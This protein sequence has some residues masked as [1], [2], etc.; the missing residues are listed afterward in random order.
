MAEC[1]DSKGPSISR[2]GALKGFGASLGLAAVGCASGEPR[3]TTILEKP[4]PA[5]PEP[6]PEPPMVEASAPT[7]R[8]T[9]PL[10][11]GPK[12]LLAGIDH[13]VVLMMENRSFD[14]YLGALKTDAGYANA[15][16]I[17]GLS[18]SE[19]NKAPD[20]TAVTVFKMDNFTPDD[21]PHT[22]ELSR[23]QWN[24]GKNDGFVKAHE[25]PS[26]HE[27]MGYHDRSQIPLY[28]W[29]ADNFSVCDNWFASVMGPTW[30]NRFYLHAATSKG[31]QS[32][33]PFLM[34]APDTVWD[35]LKEL[36]LTFKNYA[37][38]AATWYVA[39][40]VDK[41]SSLNPSATIED[42]FQDA[43]QGKLPAF[44]I[45]DPDFLA[46]DDHPDH[47]IM[48]G[49]A[50]VS[51]VYRALAASPAW[52]KTLLI[53]TYDEHGGFYDHVSPPKTVD[54]EPGFE[55]LGFR[56]PAFVIGAKVKK[57][58]VCKKQL[59]H[60]SV[61][62]TLK[63]RF[64]IGSLGRRMEAA[65]DVSDCIDPAKLFAPAPPPT[66]MPQVAMSLMRALENGVG[67]SSQPLLQEMIEAGTVPLVDDRSDRDRIKG[68]LDY[69]VD[70]G[71]I[72][73]VP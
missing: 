29:F 41:L 22:W 30:P 13:I 9:E 69:A 54:D 64:G 47:D 52:P 10:V 31:K 73:L 26:Q 5:T 67:P 4:L 71:A 28:Y 45:I 72:R 48:R 59:E 8:P 55:Q 61:A 60:V 62:A 38:G 51:S 1:D 32:N 33:S 56:V 44:S 3:P 49:Q 6:E 14:H 25:G 68:W 42:F 65:S 53:I 70:L 17:A 24:E 57:G 35:R 18:G 50:F 37:A 27:A 43:I 58:Y 7:P 12:E 39:G 23:V 66:G 21:L 63:T 2:R 36:G 34:N 16:T 46:S 19:S 11:L 40:F 20:G 15:K